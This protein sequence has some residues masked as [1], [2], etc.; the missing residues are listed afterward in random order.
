MHR[1]SLKMDIYSDRSKPKV[2]TAV[3]MSLLATVT[4]SLV[5]GISLSSLTLLSLSLSLNHTHNAS[6][7]TLLISSEV[8]LFKTKPITPAEDSKTPI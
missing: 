5:I 6:Q 1:L 2:N 4:K 7:P 3:L 8:S